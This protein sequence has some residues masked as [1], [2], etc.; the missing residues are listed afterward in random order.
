LNQNRQ[1]GE[2]M[3]SILPNALLT[4]H[5]GKSG[6]KG[7]SPRLWAPYAKQALSPDGDSYGVMASDQFVGWNG[8]VTTNVGTYSSQGGGYRSYEDTGGS[9]TQLATETGGVIRIT[10]D[11]TDNDECWL[12]HGGA[13]SVLGKVASSSGKLLIFESRFRVG[14]IVTHN[15]FIGLSEEGLAAADTVTD[16]GALASKDLLGFW[17]LEGAATSLVYGYRKAGAAVQTVG[18]FGTAIAAN[19]WYKVG[20]VFDPQAPAANR[21]KFFVDNIEQTSYATATNI[22]ASTFPDGE[23]VNFLAGIKNGAAAASSIDLDWWAFLQ[24]G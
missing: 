10:T 14:Q 4:I 24:A 18:T 3:L 2:T 22:A 12:C 19:T 15:A 21:I 11:G 16:G 17:I 23:E 1:E 8:S 9:I 20:L 5:Q 13:T 6:G 7:L